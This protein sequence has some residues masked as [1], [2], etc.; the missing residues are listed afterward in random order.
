MAAEELALLRTHIDETPGGAQRLLI[1]S[2]DGG[3]AK[4]SFLTQIPARTSVVFRLRKDA[5]LRAY[6]PPSARA[7]RCQ[8]GEA[9]PTP[10]QVRQDEQRAWQTVSL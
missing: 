5:R 1:H 10:E 8:Y 6:V 9:L 3:Y 4:K 2:V 7:G